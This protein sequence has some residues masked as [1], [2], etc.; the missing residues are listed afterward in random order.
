MVVTVSDPLESMRESAMH[1]KQTQAGAGLIVTLLVLSAFGILGMVALKTLPAYI[2]FFTIESTIKRI[3]ADPLMANDDARRVAFN[4]Q[5]Q[6]EN[7]DQVS[8]R[9]LQI[10]NG[11]II[12]HYQKSIGLMNHV[13]LVIDFNASSDQ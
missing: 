9:D 8:G 1:G 7:I 11:L 2:E 5:M 6:V 12:V 13:Q 3:A 10:G 4:R